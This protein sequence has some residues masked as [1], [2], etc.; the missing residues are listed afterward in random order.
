M[1]W[2]LFIYSMCT[3]SF[4]CLKPQLGINSFATCI[5]PLF[6]V[7][8]RENSMQL[9][10]TSCTYEERSNN[11]YCQCQKLVFEANRTYSWIAKKFPCTPLPRYLKHLLI[12]PGSHAACCRA[13]TSF[14]RGGGGSF[15]LRFFPVA[16][17]IIWYQRMNR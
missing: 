1:T 10:L 7:D 3:D 12:H 5:W 9:S 11:T 13:A 8:V 6:S 15:F 14:F 16:W 17:K 4:V 2:V